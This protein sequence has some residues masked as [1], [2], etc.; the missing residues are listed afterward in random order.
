MVNSRERNKVKIMLVF[1][2]VIIYTTE[3][4][5]SLRITFKESF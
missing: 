3:L 2:I 5:P 1:F 4:F